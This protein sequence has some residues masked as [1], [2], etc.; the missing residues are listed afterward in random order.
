MG[1]MLAANALTVYHQTEGTQGGQKEQRRCTVGVSG[2]AWALAFLRRLSRWRCHFCGEPGLV[3]RWSNHDSAH[4]Y[5]TIRARKS[6]RRQHR[7]GWRRPT[8]FL[9][10]RFW[11]QL[12]RN[13]THPSRRQSR[14]H[15]RFGV[16]ISKPPVRR[17]DNR[18]GV[19]FRP[20]RKHLVRGATGY[21]S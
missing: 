20:F 9:V 17:D 6:G 21:R 13:P 11:N 5:S 7:R 12:A 18:C 4:G 14:R 10:S 3:T 15:F 2:R 19:S 16:C 1:I 8:D